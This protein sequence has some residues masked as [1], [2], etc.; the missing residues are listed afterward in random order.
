MTHYSKKLRDS[1]NQKIEQKKKIKHDNPF[2]NKKK[3]EKR[4]IFLK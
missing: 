4:Y 1:S 3:E 2:I